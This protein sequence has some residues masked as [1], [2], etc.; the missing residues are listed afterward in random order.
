MK[1]I[2]LLFLVIKNFLIIILVD[3]RV[4]EDDQHVRIVPADD[5]RVRIVGGR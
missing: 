3:G 1:E 2:R 5:R 4:A